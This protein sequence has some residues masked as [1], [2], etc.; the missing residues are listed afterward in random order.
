MQLLEFPIIRL[1]LALIV[2][3]FLAENMS[4]D[5]AFVWVV[6]GVVLVV[7]VILLLLSRRFKKLRWLAGLFLWIQGM[8]WGLLTSVVHDPCQNVTHIVHQSASEARF[9]IHLIVKERLKPSQKTNRYMAEVVQWGHRRATGNV[10]VHIPRTMNV[11]ACEIESIYQVH[12]T[13]SPA[14]SMSNVGGFNYGAYLI[15]KQCYGTIYVQKM[16]LVQVPK[17][18]FQAAV[19]RFHER[20]RRHLRQGN[21]GEKETSLVMALLFGQQQDLDRTLVSDYQNA[22]AVHILSV[23]GLHVGFILLLVQFALGGLPNHRWQFRVFKAAVVIGCLL[24]FGALAGWAPSVLRA[25]LMCILVTIAQQLNRPSLVMH[26]LFVSLFLLLLFQPLYIWDVGFQLSYLALFAILWI[27]P[28]LKKF[29]SPEHKLVKYVWDIITVSLAAQ[30]GTVPLSLYYFHQFPLL[31]LLTNLIVL[32]LLT[33][34]MALSLLAVLFSIWIPCPVWVATLLQW[35][36]ILMNT[37]INWVSAIPGGVIRQFPCSIWLAMAMLIL[38]MAVGFY[39]QHPK[40]SHFKVLLFLWMLIPCV[41]IVEAIQL[42]RSAEFV[43]FQMPKE[44][45]MVHRFGRN[46]QV[47]H[48]S[49]KSPTLVANTLSDYKRVCQGLACQMRALPR[50]LLDHSQAILITD[51][52]KIP[53]S[54]T[55]VKGVILVHSSRLHLG[56]LLQKYHPVWVVADGSNA[57][58]MLPLW[59]QSCKRNGVLFWNT[60]QRGPFRVVF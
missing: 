3:L 25:V 44:T 39:L 46:A 18:N 34:V 28:S 14:V 32:P 19:H 31:F 54:K 16:Q 56:R 52:K 40:R 59:E 11:G 12:G 22:G 7:F 48:L 23:S 21:L 13:W 24:L 20:I 37:L 42:A 17:D 57:K 29:W 2:G 15:H 58:R 33:V 6:N 60:Q 8:A 36:L 30:L 49:N 4:L 55:K 45:L 38:V 41:G 50:S 10:I 1:T 47:Y 26:A 51:K 27:Q 43:V 35:V 9:G 5:W 53:A